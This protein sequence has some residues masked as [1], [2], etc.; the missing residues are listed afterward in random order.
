MVTGATHG[1][2]RAIV[3]RLIMA[4]LVVWGV[5]R[6]DALLADL[7]A[8]HPAG[9]LLPVVLDLASGFDVMQRAA[10]Q[11]TGPVDALVHAAGVIETGPLLDAAAGPA[12]ADQLRT[13]TIGPLLLTTV[14]SS[15]LTTGARIVF[16]NSSQA[17]HAGPETGTYAA[18][19]NALRAIA[20]SLRPELAGD[21]VGV[22]S[23]Y[24]GRTATRMQE[25]L[26]A[27]R[28][29]DYHPELLIQPESV[30]ALVAAILALP[31]DVEV[32]EV[33]IRPSVKSY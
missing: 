16:V 18:S 19:K 5:G 29:E 7:A 17:L 12:L 15:R 10:E 8:T 32:T 6:D 9:M 14:L 11:I 26:Y 30:A 23:I 24:L 31:E 21:A 25:R 3:S 33:A 22:T 20:D 27:E 28:H 1:I 2:G 4:G 13:N